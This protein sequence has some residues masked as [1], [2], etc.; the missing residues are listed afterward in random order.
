MK[1]KSWAWLFKLIITT[2]VWFWRKMKVKTNRFYTDYHKWAGIESIPTLPLDD[3]QVP[4]YVFFKDN[5]SQMSKEKGKGERSSFFQIDLFFGPLLL[6][7]QLS[8][9]SE[10]CADYKHLN[11]RWALCRLQVF[12][13]LNVFMALEGQ[14]YSSGCFCLWRILF[15][16][17]GVCFV[18]SFFHPFV[19]TSLPAMTDR[20]ES[21]A[22]QNG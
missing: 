13:L 11:Y 15:K 12:G 3:Q 20:L 5:L 19:V 22:R 18:I 7:L 2:S 17:F 8:L 4:K 16:L 1:F 9:I 21:I 10:L 6:R 14:I